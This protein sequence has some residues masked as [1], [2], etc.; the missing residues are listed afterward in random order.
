MNLQGIYIAEVL[1]NLDP[2]ERERV[3]CR[4]IGVHDMESENGIWIENGIS[5][6]YESG[7]IPQIGQKIYIMFLHNDCNKAI[8]FGQVK[9]NIE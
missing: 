7:N 3:Y 6:Y 4:V 5:N 9:Y 8:Y 2:K 1:N